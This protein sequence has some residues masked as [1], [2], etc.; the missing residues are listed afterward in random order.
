MGTSG[1]QLRQE[2][3]VQPEVAGAEADRAAGAKS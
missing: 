2:A 1:L 3:G